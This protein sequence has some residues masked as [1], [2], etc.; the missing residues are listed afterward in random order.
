MMPGALLA[1]RTALAPCD[2]PIQNHLQF[3]LVSL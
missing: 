1:R 2:E 3:L